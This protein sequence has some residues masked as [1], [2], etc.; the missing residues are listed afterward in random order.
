MEESREVENLVNLLEESHL[1][2]GLASC[3][4]NRSASED[5]EGVDGRPTSERVS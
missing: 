4:S 2:S 5:A 3:G 1:R